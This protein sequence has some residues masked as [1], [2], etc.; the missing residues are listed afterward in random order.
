[1]SKRRR[2]DRTKKSI[3]VPTEQK[4]ELR[5]PVPFLFVWLILPAILVIA[6]AIYLQGG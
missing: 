3:A 4:V 2:K 6:Y 1:M 5:S